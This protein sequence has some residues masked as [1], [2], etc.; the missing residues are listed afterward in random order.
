MSKQLNNVTSNF[1]F[2]AVRVY[3]LFFNCLCYCTVVLPLRM[4]PME[5]HGRRLNELINMSH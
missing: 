3:L 4:E 5:H 2:F 1:T